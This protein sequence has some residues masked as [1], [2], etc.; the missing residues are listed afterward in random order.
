MLRNVLTVFTLTLVAIG[1]ALAADSKADPREKVDTAVLEGIRLLEAKDYVKFLKE[2]VAPDDFKN[3][4]AKGT[5]EEFAKKFGENKG[6]RLLQ[7]LKSIKDSK[8]TLDKDEKTAT[9][10]MKE[11]IG[12]KKEIKFKKIDKYWYIQ[13]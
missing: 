3:L 8:P 13:N 11:S 6:P 10:E 9:Y 5:L 12:G 2:F 4:T 1:T 7:V